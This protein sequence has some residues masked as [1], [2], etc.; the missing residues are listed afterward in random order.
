TRSDHL[1]WAYLLHKTGEPVRAI[2]MAERLLQKKT[3]F[4]DRWYFA[5]LRGVLGMALAATGRT[6]QAFRVFQ[7][8][9]PDLVRRDQDDAGAEDVGFWRAFW[10]RAILEEY[11]DLLAKLHASGEGIAGTDFVDESFRIADIARASTVQAAIS[12]TAARAQIS[13]KGL[14]ELARRDQDTLNRVVALNQL[15]ARLAAVPEDQRLD[16]VI[17]DMRAE[18]ARLRKEHAA[19]RADIRKRFQEYAELIDPRP[20]GLAEVRSAL[21]PGEALVSIY[22]SETQSYVWTIG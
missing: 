21:A 13:D 5:Q 15:L 2:E 19:L 20:A 18:I 6:A 11:L 4:V 14:A 22:V 8:S 10:Q 16:K 1:G 3:Q 12:A 7:Q 9:L 17:G